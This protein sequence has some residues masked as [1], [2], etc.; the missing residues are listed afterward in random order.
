MVN[1]QNVLNLI[2]SDSYRQMTTEE[3]AVHFSVQPEEK[4]EFI[5]LLRDLEQQGELVKVKGNQWV[6]PRSA[7]LLVGRLQCNARGFGFLLPLEEEQEDVYIA[8]EDMDAAMHGDLVVV[9]LHQ[10]RGRRRRRKLGPAGRI[11]KVI[12]HRNRQIIGSFVPGKKFGRV[13]PDNPSL[14]RDVYVAREDWMGATEGDQVLVEIT[15]WPTLHRNP[16]GEIREVLGKVGEPGVDVQSVIL[17]FGLPPEFDEEVLSAA[18]KLPETPPEQEVARREDMRGHTTITVDPED[19][20][21][22]DDALSLYR[23]PETGRR[24]VLVHIADLSWFVEPDSVLDMEARERGTSVYLANEVVPMLPPRQSKETFSVVEGKDRLAKTVRLEFDRHAEVVDYEILHSVVNVDRRMTYTEVQEVLEGAEAEEPAAA[25]AAEKLPD[26]IWNLLHELDELAREVRA[27][28]RRIGSI[29]LDVPDYEVSV[30]EDG[31]VVSVSQIV[32]DRSHGL[33]EEFMLAA[34]RAVADFMKNEKLP[35]LYRVHEPPLEEDLEEYADFIQ[36][37]LG[38]KIDPLDRQQLQNLLS[39]VAG[40]HLADA[41]NMQLL[42]A[43]QR[44]RYSPTLKPHFALHFERYCHFTSPVRR[45][46]DLLVHQVLDRFLR[47]G[48]GARQLQSRWNDRLAPI[49][50]HCNEMQERADEAEREIVKIKLLRYL[51]DHRDE[52]FEAVVTGVI[53]I[54]MFVR[55]EDY[56]IEG[57]IKVQDIK[58]DFYK[59]DEKKKA[60]VGTRHGRTFGLG[61]PLKVVIDDIDMTRRRLDLLLHE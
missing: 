25:A 36:T 44:A 13:A 21:D 57:L 42:R 1:E 59:L 20:K 19:A 30:G 28:R 10:K 33:V 31:R 55:L 40:S 9:E 47:D 18:E 5:E 11:I 37:I 38:R 48:V 46:P 6:N 34:N 8:E 17:E 60:L 29:D 22:F 23:D 15:D 7:G 58:D 43:M 2:R 51:E 12:E 61:Q 56:S 54:G 53:E 45:Y 4:D 26:E 52:V 27:R 32:R 3:L 24:V 14:F 50:T 49:A 41:V 39:E 35:A 16:E